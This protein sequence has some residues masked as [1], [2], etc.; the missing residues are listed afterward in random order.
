MWPDAARR[1]WAEVKWIWNGIG[2]RRE[3]EDR[4]PVRNIRLLLKE[5]WSPAALGD[6]RLRADTE[7]R[8]YMPEE[9]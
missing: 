3:V 9:Y 1:T 7:W 4:T 6:E 2:E 5:S 8:G